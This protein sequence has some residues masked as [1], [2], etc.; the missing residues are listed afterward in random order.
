[1]TALRD[2]LQR[3][4]LPLLFLVLAAVFFVVQTLTYLVI[5]GPDTSTASLVG[6]LIGSV[7][8][9]AM[10]TAI[11][12]HQRARSGGTATSAEI[13]AAVRTGRVPLAADPAVWI[14]AVE[15]RHHELRRSLWLTPVTFLV[16][17]VLGAGIVT[18]E[19]GSVVG[20]ALI[21]MSVVLA[22]AAVVQARRMLRRLDHLLAQLLE[23]DA[24]DPARDDAPAIDR[25]TRPAPRT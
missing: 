3:A 1:V 8:V 22:T 18:Q 19:P 21:A 25:P 9:G 2:R 14:P 20:W 10:L 5:S 4:P 11:T 12:A 17:V 6:R 15:W 23:R 7:V 16:F 13:T 24:Q